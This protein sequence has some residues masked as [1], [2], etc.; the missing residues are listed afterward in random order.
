MNKPFPQFDVDYI[1]GVMSLR[2]PQRISL[3]RLEDILTEVTPTK[4]PDLPGA[5]ANVHNLFPICSDFE[6]DFMSL[7]FAL[8]TGV[9]KTRLMGAFITYLYCNYGYKNFFV[10]APNL[11][12]YNKL[13]GDLGDPSNPKYVFHGLGCYSK[14]PRVYADDEYRQKPLDFDE[15][16]INLFVFN[17][18]KFNSEGVKMR[19]L[20]EY[21][22]QSFFDI[23]AVLDDLVMLM[24]ES[25]HYRA[26]NGAQALNDLRPIL[27]LELTATPLVTSGSRQIPF[28]NVVYEYPLSMA[29][30]DGYTRTPYA[31]TRANIDSYQFGDE[32]LDKMM[33]LDGIQCHEKAR[34]KLEWYAKTYD[35]HI[36]KPFML[37]VCK[38]TNHA[39][40]VLN[41]IR[42][43]EFRN[44][45][46]ASKVI[47]IHSNQR[48]AEKDANIGLLLDVEKADNPVEIVIHVNI[49]KE[50]W[51][52]NNL[53]T[54]VPL[55]TATS[56]ILR[57]QT[58]GRGLRLPYGQRTGEQ[59]IDAVM[60]TAHDKFK[61]ILEEAQRGDSIFKAG[62]VI[63]IVDEPE[64]KIITTQPFLFA[65]PNHTRDAAYTET[66]LQRNE[67]NDAVIDKLA[68]DSYAG[69]MT[70]I[71]KTAA[72]GVS[73]EE[74]R[75]I[76]GEA[77]R[78][79]ADSKDLGET[80]HDNEDPF[81]DW[82]V[83][84]VEQTARELVSKYIPIPR[85]KVTDYG[86]EEY[87]FADFEIDLTEFNHA[88]ISNDLLIQNLEN[89]SDMQR[90]QGE[91]IDF[92]SYNPLK[93]LV[94]L[95]REK[96]EIDYE[97][98]SALLF[99]L[100]SAVYG[101]YIARFGENGAKNIV[102]MYR[103]D[104]SEKIY[105][106]MM[107]HFSCT[108][109]LIREEVIDVAATNIPNCYSYKSRQGIF[110]HYDS[111]EEKITSVVFDGI[112]KGVFREAK[113]DRVPELILARVL[114]HD[115]DVKNWLR[116]A[117]TQFNITYNRN[118]RYEPDFVVETEKVIYLVEVKGEDKLKDADVIS[119]KIRGVQYCQVASDWG[120][121]NGYKEW[122][123]LFIPSLQVQLSS[124][125]SNLAVRFTEVQN[126]RS[127]QENI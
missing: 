100:I 127:L 27:G 48:G 53:Y 19:K 7:T 114:E 121:A 47:M 74:C 93:V 35:K 51:D 89:A 6:R 84:Y 3:K 109:D 123:Y 86:V 11:T 9:G 92:E 85:I 124:T 117:K 20:N 30:K 17:I 98:C 81:S 37:V 49:L 101:H 87:L 103:R 88:P 62:N 64:E 90:V 14:P 107:Q 10:V 112:E 12:I 5:L 125:F 13:K 71:Q 82:I 4:N 76:A 106:Q 61:E 56:K 80:Y 25:H 45:R 33:L 16:D 113:F 2:K 59:E 18:D 110:D 34:I 75:K 46:Y 91:A 108:N 65:D 96:P 120:S 122:K 83:S 97:K 79:V 95:L 24:D 31:V 52:V 54:I 15:S 104:I 111:G 23:L 38:D 102:M 126:K 78:L 42:S 119:K 70:V 50:G 32:Q 67:N 118:K 94:G 21:L 105:T 60:L 66:G 36:V 40:W 28:K 69:L 55:R 99:Q 57:E 115:P 41:F 63:Q 72:H 29:I 1:S 58:I 26:A 22:G 77:A 43:E 68:Q 73:M 116:P 8:A 39:E 44:G